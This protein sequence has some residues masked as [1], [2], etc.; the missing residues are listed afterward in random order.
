M[1]L[2]RGRYFPASSSRSGIGHT[3]KERKKT[4]GKGDVQ[5]EKQKARQ[6]LSH[7]PAVSC[8]KRRRFKIYVFIIICCEKEIHSLFAAGARLR[9]DARRPAHDVLARRP[10]LKATGASKHCA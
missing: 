1:P 10:A 4:F 2:W 8:V 7:P 6:F 3:L 9:G 5:Q